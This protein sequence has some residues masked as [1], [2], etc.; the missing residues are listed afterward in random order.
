MPVQH[1][2]RDA[3][4][5]GGNR[6][7]VFH[8]D[9]Q[10]DGRLVEGVTLNDPLHVLGELIGA[11]LAHGEIVTTRHGVALPNLIRVSQ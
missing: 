9:T 5:G 6:R 10:L 7:I 1:A 11:G 2:Q 3:D 4:G 8:Q